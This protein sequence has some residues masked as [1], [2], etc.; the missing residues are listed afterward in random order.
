MTNAVKLFLDDR[1]AAGQ[2]DR[3]AIVTPRRAF[4]YR[5]LLGLACRAGNALRALGVEPE[6]RVAFAL[7]DGVD[8]T[9]LFFGS[10]R[11]GAVAVPLNTRLRPEQCAAL[12]R[13]S[14]AKVFVC[15]AELAQAMR[16]LRAELPHLRSCVVAGDAS[17]FPTLDELLARASPSLDPEPVSR[18]DM[19]FWLFTSGTTGTPK[20]AV[21]LH[22]DL[23]ACHHYGTEVLGVNEND[24]VF[25]TSRLFFAYALGNALLIPLHAG[26][27]VFLDPE[28]PEPASLARIMAEVRPTILFSVPT[29]YARLLRSEL[30]QHTFG[31]LRFAVSAGERL[32]GELYQA[33]RGRHGVE[34]V[35]G[36]GATET[37][38]MVLSNRPGQS[39]PDCTGT[40]VPGT[41]VRLL[42]A[43]GREVGPGEQG[44]LHVKTPSASPYYWN[45]VEHS[46][47]TFVGGWFRTGDVYTRDTDGYYSHCGREDDFF[48]VAG[49]WVC[50]SEVEMVMLTHPGVAEAAAVGIEEASG[51][52]KCF[53]FVVPK[54]ASQ[55]NDQLLAE[56]SD[57]A[58]RKLA[59]HQRPRRIAVVADLPRT[60]TGKLQR[61]VLRE[62][63]AQDAA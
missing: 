32:P 41:E 5:E 1:I 58:N 42:D 10:L 61:F 53:A 44:V 2:G 19:A 52:A 50:P 16:P 39:R 26:A 36:I 8:F 45:R 11:I 6:Q 15:G 28:W 37:V 23:Y 20:G 48:K 22:R 56:L 47:R 49:Q 51:L 24:V 34:I 57:L 9:A 18:D 54:N 43:E 60:A 31:S 17:D 62:Q 35:D 29:F 3:T 33:F 21:H 30:P 7:P 40:P 25:A 38:F 55:P 14:R 59:P 4:R 27:R 46:Q 13:D 63:F 12:L